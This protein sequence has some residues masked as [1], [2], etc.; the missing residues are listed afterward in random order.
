VVEQ[1]IHESPPPASSSET[2]ET[3]AFEILVRRHHRRLLAYATSILKDEN[4]ARDVVQD[5][6][7]VAHRR[8]DEFDTS[9]DFAAWMRGIV[10]N[11]C[12]E[13]VRAE[14]R[15]LLVP[16]ATLETV[17]QQHQ[18]WD[19]G[20]AE[21]DACVLRALQGCIGKLPDLL[22]QA[23]NLFYLQRL[24][25]ADVATRVGAEESTVRKRLQRARQTL[26]D[27]ITKTLEASA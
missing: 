25:G 9:R 7:V 24:S 10:R 1:H 22:Q 27:C 26:G 16:S 5:A 6:F 13:T 19:S 4:T 2:A 12:R 11:R 14:V 20:E 3:K 21:H 23:V 18:E 15:M 8:L 17:E